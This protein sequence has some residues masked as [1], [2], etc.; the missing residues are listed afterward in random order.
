MQGAGRFAVEIAGG[1]DVFLIG[2]GGR[3]RAGVELR[4]GGSTTGMLSGPVTTRG[5]TGTD[6]GEPRGVG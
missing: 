2:C 5:T 1:R 4:S 3:S 6:A